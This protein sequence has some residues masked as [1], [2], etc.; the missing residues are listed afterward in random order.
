MRVHELAK[1]LG[2]DSKTVIQILKETESIG[3]VKNHMSSVD[4]DQKG[5]VKL[6]LAATFTES[7]LDET[8][9]DEYVDDD[10]KKK[11]SP[12]DYAENAWNPDQNTGRHD[13]DVEWVKKVRN[14][15]V[16]EVIVERPK[17]LLGWLKGL[18]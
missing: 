4:E 7:D 14:D 5:V 18:F 8:S 6:G 16:Q 1:E 2:I 12:V 13:D 9:F 11:E 10:I 17:G 15:D 3:L